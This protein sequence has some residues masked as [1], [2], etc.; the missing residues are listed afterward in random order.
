MHGHCK[1]GE[2]FDNQLMLEEIWNA[3]R[4]P[5]IGGEEVRTG[6]GSAVVCIPARH[7]REVDV[8]GVLE[9]L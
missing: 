3:N 5:V 8:S 2:N 7:V 4:A 9:D 6:Y 1:E